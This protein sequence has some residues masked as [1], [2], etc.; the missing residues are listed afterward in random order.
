M[1]RDVVLW[2]VNIG[3][4]FINDKVECYERTVVELKK[5][6]L[7]IGDKSI[8]RRESWLRK[9]TVFQKDSKAQNVFPEQIKT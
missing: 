6:F 1:K 3:R 9:Q 4:F 5:S 7:A 8:L 2:L